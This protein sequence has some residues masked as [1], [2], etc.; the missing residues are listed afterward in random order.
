MTISVRLLRANHGDC[1][2][3]SHI[4]AEGTFNLLIDGGNPATFKYGPRLRYDGDLCIILD[5]IKAENQAIDL[6]IIT[7]I[8]DDHI[9]GLLRAFEAPG[10]L[11]EM[12]KSVWYNSSKNITD[13]FDHPEIPDNDVILQNE[14]SETSV[15]QGK[16]FEALLEEIGCEQIPIVIAG[17]VITK[18]PFKFTILSPNESNLQ[19]LL[20]VWPYEGET[21]ETSGTTT[22]HSLSLKEIWDSDEFREDASFMNGSSIAFIAEADG[23]SM[24]LLGDAHD[25]TIVESLQSLG[26][27]SESKLNVDVVKISHHGSKYNTST[28][29]LAM[30]N[31]GRYL[32]STDGSHHGLPDKRTIARILTSSVDAIV[33]FNYGPVV[34]NLLLPREVDL[35][36][37]RLH[38]LNEEVTL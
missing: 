19:Q 24:L 6:V 1:I 3:V 18:G 10:Y 35:F 20:R 32:I 29:F 15:Q 27:C 9:G 7:H 21:S 12:V 17:Q 4:S 37:K 38:I 34:E 23:K 13:Y 28:N 25:K 36:S 8:D 16:D 26:F 11:Q 33:C 22:D 31:T 5:K 30:I 14:S 2:L